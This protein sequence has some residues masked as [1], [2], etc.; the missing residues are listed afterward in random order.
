MWRILL[1]STGE[2][3]KDGFASLAEADAWHDEWVNGWIEKNPEK[4]QIYD[5][6]SVEFQQ[7]RR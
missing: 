1:K 6:P 3:L 4:D 5:C 2:L 7:C